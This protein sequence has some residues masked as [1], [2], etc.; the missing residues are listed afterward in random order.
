MV[1]DPLKTAVEVP[2]TDNA[3][4]VKQAKEETKKVQSEETVTN[5]TTGYRRTVI[6]T[7]AKEEAKK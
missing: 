3:E 5:S 2:S 6:N 4:E 1:N 7:L